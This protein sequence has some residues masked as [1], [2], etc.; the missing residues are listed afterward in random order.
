ADAALLHRS[1]ALDLLTTLV[2]KSLVVYEEDEQ[3]RG[4]YGLL[5][6]VRQYA[7][8]RLIESGEAETA[9]GR[10][11]DFFLELAE[12]AERELR[13]HE[14]VQWLDRLET[15]HDN[16]RAALEWCRAE[17]TGGEAELRLAGALVW[18]WEQRSHL[19]E[20]RQYLEAALSRDRDAPAR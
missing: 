13:R 15:E 10:H 7:Q 5:E 2:Q 16:F 4:R 17:G 12:R 19:S 20:A 8:D 1:E 11:L 6:T 9:Q 18:F 3:G 14:Q